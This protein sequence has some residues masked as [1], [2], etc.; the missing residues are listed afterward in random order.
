MPRRNKNIIQNQSPISS[1]I[2]VLNRFHN[3]YVFEKKIMPRTT[4]LGK[5]KYL[6]R[7]VHANVNGRDDGTSPIGL[8]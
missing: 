1:P 4:H 6:M 7:R 2:R 5:S 8:I 3:A